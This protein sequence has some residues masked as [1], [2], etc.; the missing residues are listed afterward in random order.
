[1]FT[2]ENSASVN[3]MISARLFESRRRRVE[4]GLE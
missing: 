1:M 2:K 4:Q 3:F